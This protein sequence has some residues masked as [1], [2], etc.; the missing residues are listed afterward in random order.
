MLLG[1][2]S[3]HEFEKLRRR[4]VCA[5]LATAVITGVSFKQAWD[6]YRPR[7]GARWKGSLFSFETIG[8]IRHFGGEISPVSLY[9]GNLSKFRG[10]SINK[11]A[12]FLWLTDPNGV[13]LVQT[14][15]HMQVVQG[16]IIIDQSGRNLS[17][18]YWARKKRVLSVWKVS[19]PKLNSDKQVIN[20]IT[21]ENMT[22]ANSNSKQNRARELVPAKIAQGKSRKEIL[23]ELM[24]E[25]QTTH[26]AASTFYHN[27]KKELELANTQ[28]QV[29][30]EKQTEE[31]A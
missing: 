16:N 9:N 31:A 19:N 26:G 28:A 20:E 7:K 8:G 24:E 29:A 12:A 15:C 21:K 1:M 17:N 13:Y 22:M 11:L 18:T 4:P 6:Y 27:V 5:V 10:K 23:S 25:L 30:E 3:D 2:P 14:R